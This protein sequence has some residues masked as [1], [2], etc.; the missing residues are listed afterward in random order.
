[1]SNMPLILPSAVPVTTSGGSQTAAAAP[2]FAG[3]AITAPGA[4]AAAQSNTTAQPINFAQALLELRNAAQWGTATPLGGGKSDPARGGQSLVGAVQSALTV[5]VQNEGES[6]PLSGTGLPLSLPV[7]EGA[8]GS[9]NAAPTGSVTDAAVLSL[10]EGEQAEVLAGAGAMPVA[11]MLQQ[12]ATASAESYERAMMAGQGSD[13][14]LSESVLRMR[15]QTQL[16]SVQAEFQNA[17]ADT[18]MSTMQAQNFAIGPQLA[19]GIVATASAQAASTL[20]D[21]AALLPPDAPAMSPVQAAP[22]SPFA[23][24]SGATRAAPAGWVTTIST[25]VGSPDWDTAM[26]EQVKFMAKNELNFAEIR[27]TPP[28]LGPV[29]VRLTLQNDQAQVTLFATHA[30]TRDALEAALPRLR[31]MFADAG[32]NLTGANVA[33]ESFAEQRGREGP[34]RDAP[35]MVNGAG[36]DVPAD[37][38]AEI[39]MLSLRGG[40]A[41]DVFA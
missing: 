16:V 33:S 4:D 27:V 3:A 29:E 13:H 36:A 23:A 5:Q 17:R 22:V 15:S 20:L 31:D 28:Q 14:L 41:L 25:P 26:G 1:M 35:E 7:V 21:A 30:A 40:G 12:A 8:I 39:R 24:D 11:L 32:L 37:E 18:L 34:G 9:D 2:A 38:P 10:A 6:L 19:S